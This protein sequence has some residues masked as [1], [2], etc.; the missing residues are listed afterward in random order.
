[1]LMNKNKAIENFYRILET[2]VIFKCSYNKIINL[3]EVMDPGLRKDIFYHISI[4]FIEEMKSNNFNVK[5]VFTH[6]I[7][8]LFSPF[9]E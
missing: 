2:R 8:R 3:I 9:I 7:F 4:R 1:M 5:N 6:S